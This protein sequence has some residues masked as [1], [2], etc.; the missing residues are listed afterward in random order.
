MKPGK[1]EIDEFTYLHRVGRTGR[2][3]RLGITVNVLATDDDVERIQTIADKLHIE[4]DGFENSDLD[5][6]IDYLEKVE[7]MNSED[8]IWHL[9]YDINQSFH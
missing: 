3:G 8:L 2:F 9:T 7:K 1:N 4:M 5:K 6:I